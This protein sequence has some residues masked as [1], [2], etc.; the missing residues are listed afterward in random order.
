MKIGVCCFEDDRDPEGGWASI[1]GSEATWVA[2]PQDLDSEVL[3]VTNLPYLTHRKLNLAAEGNVFDTQYFR[4]QIANIGVE[5]GIDHDL[6]AL[7]EFCSMTFQRVHRLGKE[8]LDIDLSSPGYRYHKTASYSLIPDFARQQPTGTSTADILDAI[9]HSTQANQAM[10][11]VQRPKGAQSVSLTFPRH[12]YGKWLLS[13][14]LPSEQRWTVVKQRENSTKFGV[15]NG[16][17]LRNTATVIDRLNTIGE[18]NALFLRVTVHSMDKFYKG[19]ASFSAGE[20]YTR[21]WATLPEIL[22]LARYAKLSINGGYSCKLSTSPL[23]PEEIFGESDMSYAR[24]LLIE[25][26]WSAL[27]CPITTQEGPR[28]TMLS[29]YLRAYDRIACGRAAAQLA[30][31]GFIVGSY[32]MGRVVIFL[33]PGEASRA[34]KKALEIGLMP[35]IGFL[36]SKGEAS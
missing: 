27:A 13:L 29:A 18:K 36:N 16:K 7:A 25:N 9:K 26:A 20:K 30:S 19:F 34:A 31:E 1:D 15:E 8:H 11:G 3:W 23:V 10:S 5:M 33:R 35:P 12:S 2:G 22:E 21:R 17:A 32:S 6:K 28:Q 14:P 4:T 24:G